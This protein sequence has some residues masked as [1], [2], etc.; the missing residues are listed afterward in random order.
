MVIE[1]EKKNQE[2]VPFVMTSRHWTPEPAFG[3]FD[4]QAFT[5]SGNTVSS[6]VGPVI[7]LH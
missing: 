7:E 5:S 1:T 6:H 4:T 2:D 3:I